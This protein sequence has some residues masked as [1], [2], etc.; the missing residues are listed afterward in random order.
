MAQS[1]LSSR[2]AGIYERLGLRP[3]INAGGSYTR[4]G[5]S[6]MA[7]QVI[8]AMEE[9][10]GGYV[11]IP[12]L[13]EAVGQ[14]IAAWLGAE[15][16]LVTCG[17]AAALTLATAA[18]VT[19][20]DQEKMKHLPDTRGMKNEVVLQRSHRVEYD[21]AIRNVGV[22]LIEVGS[23]HELEAAISSR[24]AM[25]FFLN[26]AEHR[27]QIQRKQFVEIA[28]TAGVPCLIDAAADIPPVENLRDLIALG[29]DLAAFSGGKGIRG[30][31]SSG[32]LLGHKDLIQAAFLNAPPNP[33]R[34]GRVSKVGKEE[35]VGLWKALELYLNRDH[36]ADWNRWEKQ[37]QVIAE[38]LRGIPGITTRH[39]VPVISSQV[40][41]LAIEWDDRIL[42]FSREH[43]LEALRQ[44]EPRI[45]VSPV[46]TEGPRLELSSWMLEPGEEV[47][48][49]R[50]CKE[51]LKDLA[52]MAQP[53]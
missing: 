34:V 19:R 36:Q 8:Q 41:H 3:F 35:I 37:L 53:A 47:L 9:A 4:Y 11:S 16:A 10:S 6:L 23:R 5:G 28:R 32:L 52:T 14:R 48:V 18:C 50:R 51:V 2:Q 49:A 22:R 26:M 33:D 21:H 38:A 13:Q 20:G 45:E 42:K 7:P 31:Q 40:P 1:N 46:P 17:C 43:F 39:F 25:L 24:T 30:P 12:E 44:G 15:A 27:G 29:F